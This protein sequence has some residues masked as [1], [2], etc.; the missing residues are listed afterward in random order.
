MD[1]KTI[2]IGA[3]IVPTEVNA[4]LFEG[5]DARTLLGDELLEIF[6]SADF[7]IFNLEVPLSDIREPILKSGPNL[8]ASEKCINGYK[9]LSVNLLAV[10]NNHTLDQG[11]RAFADTLRVLRENGIPYVGGGECEE[12][13]KRPFVFELSGMKFGVINFCEHEFS[14]FS[15]YG[16]GANG[17]DPLYSLDEVAAL[18]ESCD[19]VIALYHGGREHYRYPS[20]ELQ[21]ICRRIAEKGADLVICQHTHCVGARENWADCEIVYGQGNAIFTKENVGDDCWNTGMLIRL[22]VSSNGVSVDYIP[23]ERTAL[24]AK[25]SHD[26][27]ILRGFEERSAEISTPGFVKERYLKLVSEN[28]EGVRMHFS[29]FAECL[30][31]STKR[32]AAARNIINCA[33]HREMLVTYLTELHGLK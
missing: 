7:R 33:P 5:G 10:A 14:W 22:T 30:G 16:I 13:V 2:L 12:E 21:R 4:H 17:F 31:E 25:L 24:G 27:S 18:K 15:D 11:K 23:T 1:K 32:A 9:A 19:Y 20:P 3:D 29:Y 8:A 28:E 26:P 6:K